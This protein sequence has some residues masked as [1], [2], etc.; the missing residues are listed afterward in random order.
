MNRMSRERSHRTTKAHTFDRIMDF[1]LSNPCFKEEIF[2]LV[3]RI[4]GTGKWKAGGAETLILEPLGETIIHETGRKSWVGGRRKRR[5][6]FD[7][8]MTLF[9]HRAC[10]GDQGG[11]D[12][13]LRLMVAEMNKTCHTQ[14]IDCCNY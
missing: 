12:T 6:G 1:G 7:S 3:T 13:C 8:S 5:D 10:D 4:G 11:R 2:R 9:L 14:D